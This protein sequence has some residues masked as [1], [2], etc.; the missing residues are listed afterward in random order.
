M[1]EVRLLNA[2]QGCRP[3]DGLQG[4]A[5]SQG[6]ACLFFSDLGY[7]AVKNFQEQG[8]STLPRLKRRFSLDYFIPL[9]EAVMQLAN[10]TILFHAMQAI[11]Q[12]RNQTPPDPA[13]G[14]LEVTGG[15]HVCSVVTCGKTTCPPSRPHLSS[16]GALRHCKTAMSWEAPGCSEHLLQVHS[17]SQGRGRK[18]S[19]GMG[20]EPD[21]REAS[22]PT[23]L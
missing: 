18:W 19:K 10:A 3:R 11:A 13:S 15:Q 5:L 22:P 20:A 17:Q 2:R 12:V 1:E 21:H 4:V 8:F 16:T 7:V 14:I 9:A 23:L 6:L